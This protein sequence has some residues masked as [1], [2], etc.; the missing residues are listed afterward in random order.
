MLTQTLI[1]QAT[2][3]F[4]S[5]ECCACGVVFMIPSNLHSKIKSNA[6]TFY[7]PNG[8]GQSYVKSEADKLRDQLEIERKKYL[9][10]LAEKT[11]NMLDAINE[12]SNAKKQLSEANRKV[13]RIHKGV[14]PCCNRT[15]INLQRHMETKHPFKKTNKI[16]TK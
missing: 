15:F 9:Q 1:V 4:T 5:E 3:Q 7:C 12:A 16:E 10:E 11:D 6:S 13:K 14:C 8:H 2:T